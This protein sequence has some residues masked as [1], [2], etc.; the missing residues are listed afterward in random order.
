[1]PAAPLETSRARDNLPSPNI[2]IALDQQQ[3]DLPEEPLPDIA[4]GKEALLD[5][6]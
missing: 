3:W 5:Q 6:S 4:P 1:M 2:N